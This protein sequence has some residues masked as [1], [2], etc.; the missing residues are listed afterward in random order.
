M[1]LKPGLH[2][3]Y[4]RS[5]NGGEATDKFYPTGIGENAKRIESALIHQV[6]QLGDGHVWRQIRID[7]RS[8]DL[9]GGVDDLRRAYDAHPADFC[10]NLDQ[11]RSVWFVVLNPVGIG[12][13]SVLDEFFV[14]V[15]PAE[16]VL[17]DLLCRHLF[18]LGPPGPDDTCQS[19]YRGSTHRSEH[20]NN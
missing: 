2:L 12:F 18:L 8:G 20:G 19:A 13:R 14:E 6:P 1:Q 15:P 3:A 17:R 5:L 7:N 10:V 11:G 16:F 9:F 4:G